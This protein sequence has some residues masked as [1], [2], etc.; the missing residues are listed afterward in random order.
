M[1]AR[2][3]FAI[4]SLFF[5][6][7]TVIWLRLDRS[8]PTWDDSFYLSNSLVMYDALTEGGLP[9]YAR[10]SLTVMRIKPPLIA[11]L[12]TP[13]Y[14]M[15]GRKPRAALLVNLAF[16]LILFAALYAL[17]KRYA[18]RRA[19]LIALYIAGT[20]P[21]VYG[22]ARWYLV[23]CGLTAIVCVA[24]VLIAGFGDSA[25]PW[26]AFLL[27]VTCG[28]GLLMKFSFPLY[29]VIPL[30]YL[31]IR[32]RRTFLRP[33]TLL[34]FAAP[35]LALALPWYFLNV[36]TALETALIAG[37]GETARLYRTGGL[38][39][40][41]IGRYFRHAFNAGTTI[42]FVALPVLALVFFGTLRAAGKRGLLMCALWGSPFLFLA[43][44]HYRELRYA[45]PLYP[46][47]ALALGILADAALERRGAGVAVYLALALPALSLLQTSFG[48]LGHPIELGGLLFIPPRLDYARTFTREAWPHQ[49]ILADIYRAA[50]FQGDERKTLLLGSDSV[51]FNSDNFQLAVVEKRLPFQVG[52]TAYETE[53]NTLIPLVDSAAYFIYVEGGWPVSPFNTRA[54]DAVKEVRES[55]KFTELPIART[56]PD[57]GVAHVFANTA[58]TGAFVPA[59]LDSVTDCNVTFGGKLR[60]TGLSLRRTPQ[61]IDVTYRWRC[62][63]PLDRNYWCFTHIVDGKGAVAGY[64]DHP[65]LNGDPPTSR[66]KE[67]DTAIEKRSFRF[68]GTQKGESY[69]L[70]LGVFDRASGERLPITASDFPLADDRTA[71]VV[72][73]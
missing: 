34:A 42:Y 41:D 23:D 16:L 26:R 35:A 55:G 53:L 67:G 14:L 54:A 10:Q 11:L 18:S 46:A 62:L 3:V 7:T 37:T 51:R 70:R 8:P 31:A 24:I 56:L 12:P 22:L 73:E 65:I 1:R 36:R 44:G 17:G 59:G 6:G 30:V 32:E 69:R 66:W 52:A 33:R 40:A 29:V 39:L 64:L 63:K 45:E 68:S 13:V 28:L 20:M 2:F 50:K 48:V 19:G 72:A 60:L 27:G 43:L 15:V 58:L 5:L 57:G 61:G 21:L 9:A 49:E 4:L 25:G 47:V 71:A 38:S